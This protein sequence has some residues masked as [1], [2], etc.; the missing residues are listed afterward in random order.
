V[1]Q[2]FLFTSRKGLRCAA[3]PV[4]RQR[5]AGEVWSNVHDGIT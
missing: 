1:L 4:D 3:R 5:P 2:L